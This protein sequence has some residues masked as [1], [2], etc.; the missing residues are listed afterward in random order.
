MIQKYIF[1]KSKENTIIFIHGLYANSGFWLNYI[2]HFKDYKIILYNIDYEILISDLSLMDE[3]A[4]ECQVDENNN[5]L[6]AV[7]AHSLGTILS[8]LV[9]SNYNIFL[10][11]ICQIAI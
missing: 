8:D 7:V 5:N 11:N 3:V 1:N 4:K 2:V 9:F 6:I 10:S